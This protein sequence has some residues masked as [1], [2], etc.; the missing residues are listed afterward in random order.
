VT[1]ATH[2]LVDAEVVPAPTEM[3]DTANAKRVAQDEHRRTGQLVDGTVVDYCNHSVPSV[4]HDKRL[5]GL[6]CMVQV[7]PRPSPLHHEA[8][9]V[10]A[11]VDES[12]PQEEGGHIS[13]PQ[14]GHLEEVVV[15]RMGMTW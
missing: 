12:R 14:T 9:Y 13:E 2:G 4:G 3:E 11:G 8:H 15:V 6:P 7:S 10:G 5:A 1:R